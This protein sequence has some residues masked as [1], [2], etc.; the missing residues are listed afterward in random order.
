MNANHDIIPKNTLFIKNSKIFKNVVH[1]SELDY[2][3]ICVWL[4][5]GFFWGNTTFFKDIKVLKPS[6]SFKNGKEMGP[7]WEWYYEPRNISFSNV[8]DEFIDLFDS[9]VKDSFKNQKII[10]PLSGGLDSRTLAIALHRTNKNVES[11]SYYFDGGH[12]ESYYGK[13]IA[14]EL[15]Y[16]HSIFKVAS[17]YLWNDLDRISTINGCYSEFTHPRQAAFL[18]EYQ[19]MGDVF[20]LGHWGDVLFDNLGLNKTIT[21]NEQIQFLKKLIIKKGG[22]QLA[23]EL[24]RIWGLEGCFDNYI[25]SQLEYYLSCI[26]I[27]NSPNSR[28]RAFKNLHWAPRWNLVNVGYFTYSKSAIIPYYDNDFCKFICTVPEE[29]LS[30]RKIQIEYIKRLSPSLAK[31]TWQEHRPFNLYNY[32]YDRFPYNIPYRVYDKIRRT[33]KVNKYVNMNWELQFLGKKNKQF[34][35]DNLLGSKVIE[36]IVPEEIIRKYFNYFYE[37]DAKTYS[38]PISMLLTLNQFQKNITES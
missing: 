20:C 9:V 30:S 14:D 31:Q 34:V 16:P 27:D 37:N 26:K 18:D 15:G 33:I 3:S 24:W 6:H 12:N 4:S 7:S 38:H 29:F 21:L 23:D 32:Q 22:Y 36:N 11:F 2:K 17:G 5:T 10:L 8:V 25:N 1:G 13:M 19:K 28:L 35:F